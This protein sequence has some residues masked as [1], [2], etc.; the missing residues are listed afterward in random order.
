MSRQ[1]TIFF[2]TDIHGSERCF[3]KFINAEKFFQ[4]GVLIL[5]GDITG[6]AVVAIVRQ[7]NGSNYRAAFLGET[8]A[9]ESEDAVADFERQV[10]QAGAYPLRTT[11][12]EVAAM[13]ADR[14]LVD[15]LF[16]RLMV[17]SVQRWCAIPEGRLRGSGAR[18]FIDARNHDEMGIVEV[19]K[20]G[21]YG[22]V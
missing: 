2:A 13:E 21:T 8:A 14:A 9:L 17:E 1:T 7:A 10:R 15:R 4:A 22:E 11:P 6:K 5:G 19:L 18:C 3:L 16:S 12:E 20:Q